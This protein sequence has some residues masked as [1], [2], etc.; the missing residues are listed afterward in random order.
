MPGAK[1]AEDDREFEQLSLDVGLIPSTAESPGAASDYVLAEHSFSVSLREL[2]VEEHPRERLLEFGAS[3][4]STA[5]L[6]TILIGTR[7]GTGK[8]SALG[9]GQ[10]LLRVLG[11]DGMDPFRRLREIGVE[12][13]TTV[14]GIGPAKA[15]A[16]VA[17]VELGKRIFH[18]KPEKR[19]VIDDPAVAVAALSQDLMWRSQ[20]CFAIALLDVKHRLL[21]TQVVT[22]GTATET[23]VHPRDVFK[24]AIHRGATRIIIAHNHPSGSVEPS[25]TDLELTRQFLQAALMIG[26]PVL[27]HLIL[28]SGEFCSLR[29]TTGLWHEISQQEST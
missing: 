19:T 26:I 3:V 14:V 7:Q 9:L 2:P 11:A 20:E 25:A 12:E 27:D 4:L 17:A 23:L 10:Q 28:G 1:T 13:L 22:I 29:Q 8:F 16:I 24:A 15:A 5:E 21:G 6:F 18:P